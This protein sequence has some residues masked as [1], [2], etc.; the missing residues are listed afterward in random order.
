MR[1]DVAR[2]TSPFLRATLQQALQDLEH[3][4]GGPLLAATLL[5][6][7]TPDSFLETAIGGGEVLIAVEDDAL[8]GMALVRGG[9]LEALYVE[10]AHRR[11]GI[12]RALV[13]RAV[14]VHEGT[15]DAYAL[16]GDRATKS[17]YESVGWKTRLLTMRGE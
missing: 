12:G 13:H 16:P 9:V 6:P 14:E 10:P 2:E 7:E 1:I 15:L 4:R 3:K 8:V 17:L 11:R 5:G